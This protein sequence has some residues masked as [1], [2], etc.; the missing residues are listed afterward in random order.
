M[1]NP[2]RRKQ[3]SLKELVINPMKLSPRAATFEFVNRP[4]YKLIIPGSKTRSTVS[5]FIVFENEASMLE[6][7]PNY[8]NSFIVDKYSR[9][10]YELLDY[11][12]EEPSFLNAL[13]EHTKVPLSYYDSYI[14][15]AIQK[16][17]GLEALSDKYT[18]TTQYE[19]TAK[20]FADK[21]VSV[22]STLIGNAS[23]DFLFKCETSQILKFELVG[24]Y[25]E[26]S[27]DSLLESCSYQLMYI[28]K[29]CALGCSFCQKGVN[30]DN[31]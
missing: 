2:Y 22:D 9:I 31:P 13:A 14:A 18:L 16:P 21:E 1:R 30:Y 7:L 10:F 29:E 12:L 5:T 24:D 17:Y 19:I 26:F 3:R 8:G 20:K 4:E 15:L 25:K 28:S 23:F 27:L 6:E 11:L